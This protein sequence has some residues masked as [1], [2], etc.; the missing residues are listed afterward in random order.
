[1]LCHLTPVKQQAERNQSTKKNTKQKQNGMA[2]G[3]H[4]RNTKTNAGDMTTE[5][6]KAQHQREEG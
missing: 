5:G 4:S 2:L 6:G 1:M 3:D